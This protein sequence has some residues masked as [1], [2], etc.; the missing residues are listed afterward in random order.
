[1]MFKKISEKII[2]KLNESYKK[3][4]WKNNYYLKIRGKIER[5]MK[6]GKNVLI[7]ENVFF[8]NNYPYLINIG[9]DCVITEGTKIL[10]HDATLSTYLGGYERVGKV[11]I[12]DNCIIGLNSI[13]L[14]GVTIGPNVIIAAGSVVNKDIPPNS[15]VSGVPARFYDK[16]EN[17]IEKYKKN[18]TSNPRFDT[19][20]KQY[21]EREKST[22]FKDGIIKGA[23]G[24]DVFVQVSVLKEWYPYKMRNEWKRLSDLKTG[25]NR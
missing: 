20:D 16:F 17:V 19:N 12:K 7:A 18:I 1:M 4:Y 8:D 13:I 22:S 24:Q 21:S 23:E 2:N 14:P 5:G 3:Y 15:C 11:D 25:K 9:N 6:V 10:T